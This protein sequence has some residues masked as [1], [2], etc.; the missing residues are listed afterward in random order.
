MNLQYPDGT[1]L[2]SSSVPPSRQQVASVPQRPATTG[3]VRGVTRRGGKLTE[4]SRARIEPGTFQVVDMG[5]YQEGRDAQEWL[6][7]GYRRVRVFHHHHHYHVLVK[8]P[9]ATPPRDRHL[10]SP[11]T[12]PTPPSVDPCMALRQTSHI[13]SVDPTLPLRPRDRGS[14]TAQRRTNGV[15]KPAFLLPFH[16]RAGVFHLPGPGDATKGVDEPVEEVPRRGTST[17][18]TEA[19]TPGCIICCGRYCGTTA[20]MCPQ[21]EGAVAGLDSVASEC[22]ASRGGVCSLCMGPGTPGTSICG[23]CESAAM[24]ATEQTDRTQLARRINFEGVGESDAT[25]KIGSIP[26]APPTPSRTA[27]V[28]TLRPMP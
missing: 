23:A 18:P 16:H 2:K 25:S 6:E 11:S 13:V 27:V 17:E 1:A 5:E 21:C 7:K 22:G 8:K 26:P 20:E 10:R 4:A 12:S 28:F 19:S 15:S 24:E 3:V 9:V 14:F